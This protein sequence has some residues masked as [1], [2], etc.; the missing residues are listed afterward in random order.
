MDSPWA[1]R[2]LGHSA[3]R[4]SLFGQHLAR[5]EKPLRIERGLDGAHQ[6]SLD[7][8]LVLLHLLEQHA[9]YAALGITDDVRFR[10]NVRSVTIP[11]SPQGASD[12]HCAGGS[13]FKANTAYYFSQLWGYG[14]RRVETAL[15]IDTRKAD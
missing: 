11:C 1:H 5:I 12:L 9:A 3:L 8:A 13:K 10:S 15:G 7:R 2:H 6:L 14:A 4:P